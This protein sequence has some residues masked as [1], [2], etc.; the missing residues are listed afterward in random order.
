MPW[1]T[2]FEAPAAA[3]PEWGPVVPRAEDRWAVFCR[4]AAHQSQG[5]PDTAREA[6]DLAFD[7]GFFRAG[8]CV[9]AVLLTL[10]FEPLRELAQ[11]PRSLLYHILLV[12]RNI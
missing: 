6:Q 10:C 3:H 5:A 9:P 12:N 7:V 1:N 11:L 4:R 2:L 8:L